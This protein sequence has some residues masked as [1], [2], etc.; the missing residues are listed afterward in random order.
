MIYSDGIHLIS[1]ESLEE[2]HSFC[3]EIEIKPCWFHT[4]SSFPHYDIPKRR[5]ETIFED[6]RI[7]RVT[8]REIVAL[9]KEAGL[10]PFSKRASENNGGE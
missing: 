7:Q 8:P 2:L 6:P 10:T 5:R 1:N 4:G 9:L 3:E